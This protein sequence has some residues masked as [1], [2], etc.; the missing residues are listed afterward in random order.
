MPAP[1]LLEAHD[2]RVEYGGVIALDGVSLEVRRGEI[3]GLIGANGAGK[4]TF[5]NAVSGLAP[6]TGSIRFRGVELVG[7]RASGRSALGAARTFQDVGLLRP[8]S[9]LE[10]VL[11]AQTW[12]ARYAAAVGIAGL[13]GSVRT[14]S[15]LRRRARLAL[16][17][18]GLD[19]LAGERLG[20]LPYG[21]MRMVEIASAVAAGPDLLL[22]DEATAGLGP[23]ESHD[24]GDR[25]LAVR[26]ELGLTLVI[27]E[28]HVPLV[29]RVCDYAYC[30]ESGAVIAEGKPVD[31]TADPRVVE[32][33]L[34][35]G[36]RRRRTERAMSELGAETL[37]AV[38]DL[39]AGYGSLPVLF[40][41]DLDVRVGEIVA[42]M[43]ANGAG[44][45]TTLRAITGQLRATRGRVRFAGADI[46]NEPTE[47]LSTRGMSLVPEGR[48]M[49]RDLTVAEN[50]EI[51]A[52]T[53][54]RPARRRGRDRACVHV[55][56][57]PRRAEGSEGRTALGRPAADAGHRPG[58]DE[59]PAPAPRR[60]GVARPVA[61]H[62]GDGLR[63]HRRRAAYGRHRRA[64]RRA[65]RGRAR[66]RRPR[67]RARTGGGRR[68]RRGGRSAGDAGP[69][70]R[71][72]Y[73][74]PR[75][76]GPHDDVQRA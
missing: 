24:L 71:D 25:F 66:P 10:N 13:G 75:A 32:S 37:L 26:D 14:E 47:S 3:V 73:L 1:A 15:E 62:D 60:R 6:V 36:R 11:L 63:P 45:T 17:L 16:E 59:Q 74:G 22:L 51:G 55:V 7:R 27:V 58:A 49:L 40:G 50:L 76:P 48:G 38:E 29:V 20:S 12:L 67:V 28:H 19:H 65:E 53:V 35:R 39:C 52:Y 56:P 23:E 61:G 31:V 72:A 43:G 8:E 57:D 21:T 34:G 54:A 33:F 41:V 5:F 69:A 44:K 9:V 2:V 68:P 42:L 4:S 18:L 30:L 46:T 70:P 64:P